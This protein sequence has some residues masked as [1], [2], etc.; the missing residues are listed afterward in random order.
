MTDDERRLTRHLGIAVA[1][2][3]VVLA[4][5]WWVFVRDVHAVADADADQIPAEMAITAAAPGV[6]Q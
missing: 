6:P 1:V 4:L 3:L 5:L 2:K